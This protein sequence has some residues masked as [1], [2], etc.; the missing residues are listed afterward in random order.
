VIALCPPVKAS[1]SKWPEKGLRHSERDLPND[2]QKFRSFSIPYS[3]A[4][5][6]ESYSVL[7]EVKNIDKP[8]MV[9]I[10]LEDQSV[11]PADSEKIVES[12]NNP[13]VVRQ[14]GIGHSFRQS[15]QESQLVMSKIEEFL[16]ET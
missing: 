14:A 12:A 9:F 5:D 8:L 6:M 2:S 13:Y 1:K 16:Q 11:D 15:E 4:E 10:A 7:D 3:F